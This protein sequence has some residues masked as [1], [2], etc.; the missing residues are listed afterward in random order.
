MDF[1]FPINLS[2]RDAL[3][4]LVVLL[5]LYLIVAFLRIRRLKRQKAVEIQPPTM[6]VQSAVA[7]YAAVQEPELKTVPEP[8]KPDPERRE[9]E[10]L[11][12]P[13]D[14]AFPWNEPPGETALLRQVALLESEVAQLRKEVGGLRAEVL[15]L[16][17]AQQHALD[18]AAADVPEEAVVEDA[19][20]V[21]SN[22]SPLYN[23]AMQFALQG[24]DAAAI[25]QSCGISRA[26]AELVVALVRNREI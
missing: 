17:E 9:P 13:S 22:V 6:A 18:V 25:S 19:V 5:A 1:A 8:A 26:E 20:E 21:T 15:M 4:A 14:A 2:L 10:P 11:A 7:A 3:I 24:L 12:A 16:R 23:E